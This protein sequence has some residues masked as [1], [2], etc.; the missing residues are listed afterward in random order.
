MWQESDSAGAEKAQIEDSAGTSKGEE[1]GNKGARYR[2]ISPLQLSKREGGLGN[3]AAVIMQSTLSAM[4]FSQSDLLLQSL[5]IG[6]PAAPAPERLFH[7]GR[8]D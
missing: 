4:R 1:R 3:H 7:L 5:T 8:P 6:T 2:S